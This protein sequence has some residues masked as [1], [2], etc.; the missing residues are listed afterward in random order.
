MPLADTARRSHQDLLDLQSSLRDRVHET[1]DDQ[2]AAVLET[3]AEALG[4]LA[5]AFADFDEGDEAAWDR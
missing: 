4:G 5:E 1:D 2:L 3:A